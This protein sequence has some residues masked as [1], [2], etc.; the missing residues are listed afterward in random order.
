[1][2]ICR[3]EEKVQKCMNN[4]RKCIKITIMKVSILKPLTP[5][6]S[7][8]LCTLLGFHSQDEEDNDKKES[9]LSEI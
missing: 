5:L 3:Y 9:E 8:I 7:V 2:E 4:E 6:T 1:M